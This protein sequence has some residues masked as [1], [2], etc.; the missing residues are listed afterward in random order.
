MTREG[1][2]PRAPIG[3]GIG[4]RP[5]RGWTMPVLVVLVL[6]AAG[7]TSPVDAEVTATA[8]LAEVNAHPMTAEDLDRASERSSGSLRSRSMT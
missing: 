5:P 1:R 7:G 3:T 8:R 2:A 4:P 6:A